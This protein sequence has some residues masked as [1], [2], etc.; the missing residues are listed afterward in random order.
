[1]PEA[2]EIFEAF[3]TKVAGEHLTKKTRDDLKPGVYPVDFRA[4]ITGELTV[5][6]NTSG[7]TN[8]APDA[9]TVAALLLAR[10]S[11]KQRNA[12]AQ[13]LADAKHEATTVDT[14]PEFMKEAA[15]VVELL[16]RAEPSSKRGSVTGSF[17]VT[18]HATPGRKVA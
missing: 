3:A 15:Q 10:M 8:K 6:F 17:T 9:K 16:T 18:R 2:L 1:M 11:R 14:D 13:E 12:F 5:G 7:V 4:R